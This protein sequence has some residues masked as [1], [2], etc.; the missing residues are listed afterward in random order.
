MLGFCPSLLR[1]IK[2]KE[3]KEFGNSHPG[4]ENEE[5]ACHS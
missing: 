5:E 2:R 1:I 3:I 4:K